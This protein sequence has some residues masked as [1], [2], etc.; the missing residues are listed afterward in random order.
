MID[1]TRN[2][3]LLTVGL[4][5]ILLGIAGGTMRLLG[6]SDRKVVSPPVH[7]TEPVVHAQAPPPLPDSVSLAVPF[8]PQAPFAVWDNFHEQSCEE[9]AILM[10]MHYV[11]GEGAGLLNPTSVDSELHRVVDWER[12]QGLPQDLTAQQAV[13]VFNGYYQYSAVSLSTGVSAEAIKTQLAAGSLVIL[14]EAGRELHNPDYTPPGPWY[15]FILIKGYDAKGNFI[16]ND[17]G[18]K[19]GDGWVFPQ[20]VLIAADHDWAGRDPLIDQGRRVMIIV[21][22]RT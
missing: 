1:L 8:T 22:N 13:E 7:E 10:T 9:A 11:N 12:A 15:H 2:K 6:K 5:I 21:K 17:A 19:Q 20:G 14:P 18:I 3:R 4:A 16:T